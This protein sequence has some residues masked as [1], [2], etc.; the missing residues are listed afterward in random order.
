VKTKF[1][2]C[3]FLTLFVFFDLSAQSRKEQIF[4]LI[5]KVDSLNFLLNNERT[6]YQAQLKMFSFKF[7]SIEGK[8]MDVNK[9]IEKTIK[10]LEDKKKESEVIRS[11]KKN[12][13]SDIAFLDL[14]NLKLQMMLDS[15]LKIRNSLKSSYLE[16]EMVF[17]EGGTFQMGSNAGGQQS[18]QQRPQHA[19]TL[20]SYY[21]GK[22]EVTQAQWSEV[23]GS[24]PSYY[25]GCDI[26]PVERVSW[27]D[28]QEFIMKLNSKTGRV[29]RLPTEAEWEFAA[30]GGVKSKGYLYSGSND[31]NAVAWHVGIQP[32][33][34]R[35]GGTKEANELGI[36]DM[37]GNVDEWCS[38]LYGL[39]SSA[40][41][42]NP[43]GSVIGGYHVIRGGSYGSH[44]L[45][46]RTEDRS[47][48]DRPNN[49]DDYTGFRL[50]LDIK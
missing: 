2:F 16:I 3:S 33:R 35:I 20:S 37:S 48:V 44:S 32:C 47:V 5:N 18:S 42:T 50:V 31:V 14:E 7:D 1:L 30:K 29:Y 19:V 39:Y 26:C 15:A 45:F 12:L 10:V 41:Q 34:T 6:N 46:C 11:K 43:Q 27:N 36:Y 38:D 9:D 17:V 4:L 28:V 23:M 25:Q 8:I 13:E 24:N 40:A 49:F 21:I 22:Y